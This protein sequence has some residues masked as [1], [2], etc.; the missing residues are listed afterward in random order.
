MINNGKTSPQ[1]TEK[2]YLYTMTHDNTWNNPSLASSKISKYYHDIQKR[3]LSSSQG[4]STQRKLQREE[5][6]RKKKHELAK[7]KKSAKHRLH[8]RKNERTE[9][10]SPQ[11]E[12]YCRHS[13][14]SP[15]PRISQIR[16][17]SQLSYNVC[18]AA[19][20]YHKYERLPQPAHKMVF[21]P[22][23]ASLE[24]CS[25]VNIMQ[26]TQAL[27][28]EEEWKKEKIK[29]EAWKQ[30]EKMIVSHQR[31]E[32]RSGIKKVRVPGESFE[33]GGFG[34]ERKYKASR[35][36]ERL[37]QPKS[38]ELFGYGKSDLRGV[39]NTSPKVDESFVSAES[40]V[41]WASELSRRRS[42]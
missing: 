35:L 11:L 3:F 37:S 9:V 27:N 2:A 13:T 14:G 32:I 20:D 30:R 12:E 41:L 1:L 6:E 28:Q 22:K 42:A 8:T 39:V 23:I 21:T 31:N 38:R 24:A 16:V 10:R 40:S 18:D 19:K 4:P 5:E 7:H 26:K 33:V 25:I 17:S 15:L 36:V 34:F 29:I